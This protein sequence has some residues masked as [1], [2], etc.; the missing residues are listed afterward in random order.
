M[1]C[2]TCGNENPYGNGQNPQ[3]D[4]F[5]RMMAQQQNMNQLLGKGMQDAYIRYGGMAANMNAGEGRTF[6]NPACDEPEPALKPTAWH[7]LK[8]LLKVMIP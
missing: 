4:Y 1:R 6:G 7:Q 3:Q 5:N 2:P 8:A